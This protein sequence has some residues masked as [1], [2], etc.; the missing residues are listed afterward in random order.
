M[1][2]YRQRKQSDN[3]K[4]VL[5]LSNAPLAQNPYKSRQSL[6]KAINKCRAEVSQS[7]RKKKAVV[8]GLAKEVG[9]YLQDQYEKQVHGN[10]ISEELKA[11]IK[12]FYT[13]LDISYTMPGTKDKIAIWDS[14]AKKGR[15]RKYYLTMYLRKAHAV[16]KETI[17]DRECCSSS[18]FCKLRPKNVLLL[19]DIPEEQC[20]CQIHENFF[21][22]LEAMGCSYDNEFSRNV[23]CDVSEKSK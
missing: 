7:T 9:L 3:D 2:Q 5:E 11:E 1:K 22:K 15:E 16:F 20:K 17:A 6:R 18:A 23:L 10:T 8:L 4:P 12:T 19:V 21:M 13:R 14:A